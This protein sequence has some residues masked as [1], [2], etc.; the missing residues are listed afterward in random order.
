MSILYGRV[1]IGRK[2]HILVMQC[3]FIY[4]IQRKLCMFVDIHSLNGFDKFA[5]TLCG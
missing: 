3:Y 2:Q 4:I 1:D 5:R